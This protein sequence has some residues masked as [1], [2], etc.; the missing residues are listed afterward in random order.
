MADPK[1][2]IES[3]YTAFVDGWN[4]PIRAVA[5][6]AFLEGYSLGYGVEDL[7]HMD[8]VTVA[9]NFDRWWETNAP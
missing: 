4:L 5:R 9:N 6:I 2:E 1:T 7:E 8:Y 3:D